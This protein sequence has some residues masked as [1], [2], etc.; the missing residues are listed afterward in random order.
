LKT[1]TK[2]LILRYTATEP[3]TAL[4]LAQ[5]L[6]IAKRNINENMRQLIDAGLIKI[7]GYVPNSPGHPSPMYCSDM[8][9]RTVYYVKLT[10]SECTRRYRQNNKALINA[11]KGKQIMG[12]TL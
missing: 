7:V 11:R 12:V 8:K 2:A 1:P 4:E 5:L 9:R 3:K 6:G 10:G